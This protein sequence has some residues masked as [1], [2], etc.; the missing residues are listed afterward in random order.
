MK[1]SREDAALIETRT[2]PAAEVAKLFRIPMEL[3]VSLAQR[4]KRGR[5]DR[6]RKK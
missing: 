3:L 1:I 6:R 5:R 2:L 4:P